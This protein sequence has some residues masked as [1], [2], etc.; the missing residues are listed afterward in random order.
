MDLG[1]R[2]KQLRQNNNLSVRQLAKKVGVTASFIYQLEQNKVSP[3]FST[4]KSIAS[5]LNT[6]MTLLVEDELPEEWV[7]VRKEKR[8]KVAA[9]DVALNV[10]LLTFLGA[11]NK[12]MQPLVFTVE[13]GDKQV[14]MPSFPGEHEEFVYIIQGELE[15][16][17][18]N[19]KYKLKAGDAAYFMFDKPVT[20]INVGQ[21]M[22][23][24]L[25]LICPPGV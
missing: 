17:T 18:D 7:I 10:Q 16:R 24:G 19:A 8:K 21:D 4:L 22:V 11:R 14:Q 9:E 2:V 15:I 5:A 12:K 13:P 6:S 20:V 23:E 1:S 3:S 25:W